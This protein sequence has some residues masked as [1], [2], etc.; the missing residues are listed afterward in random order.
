MMRSP[1]KMIIGFVLLFIGANLLLSLLG[2][3]L[4]GVLGLVIA[5]LCF[6][7]GYHYW[8]DETKSNKLGAGLLIGFGVVLLLG[9]FHHLVG[10]AIACLVMV[11]GYQLM[12]S[13][14]QRDAN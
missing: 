13:S 9:K 4:G 14:Q 10:I 5:I 6:Y 12:K 11:F 2:I 1:Y 8:K 7:F 3:H